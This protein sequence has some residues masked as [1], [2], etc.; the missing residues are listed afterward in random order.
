MTDIRV[1]QVAGEIFLLYSSPDLRVSQVAVEV[2]SNRTGVLRASQIAAEI[3]SNR[4]GAERVSQVALEFLR[5]ATEPPPP[6]SGWLRTSQVALEILK[7]IPAQGQD[8]VTPSPNPDVDG[9]AD[10]AT[11]QPGDNTTP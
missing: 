6:D 11:T 7:L 3:L 4:V 9:P 2:F 8:C 1:S 10:T 5:A